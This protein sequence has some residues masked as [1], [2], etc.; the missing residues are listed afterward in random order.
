[1]AS[2]LFSLSNGALDRDGH[3]LVTQ[4]GLAD[5]VLGKPSKAQNSHGE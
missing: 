2:I 1:M 3:L 4:L 5:S